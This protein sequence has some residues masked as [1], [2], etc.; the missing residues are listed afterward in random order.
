MLVLASRW[1]S[2]SF[3][4]MTWWSPTSATALRVSADF[5]RRSILRACTSFRSFTCARTN[6]WAESVPLR[7][8]TALTNLSD[9]AKA[10]GF[11]G[12]SLDGKQRFSKCMTPRKKR[13]AAHGA[14]RVPRCLECKTYRWYGHSE[15]DPAKY[16]VKEEVDAWKK[17][18]P[19]GRIRE[20][21]DGEETSERRKEKNRSPT[22]SRRKSMRRWNSPSKAPI[23]MRP[24]LRDHIWAQ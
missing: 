12:I 8:Q 11:P 23:P 1:E 16:R 17:K 14:G 19:V 7:L 10:Y 5:T 22:K 3:G 21:V 24:S 6:L 2:R 9:R 4:A 13:S 18:D 15:I 20:A